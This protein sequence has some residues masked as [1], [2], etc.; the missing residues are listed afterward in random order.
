MDKGLKEKI[1]SLRE[2][3]KSYREISKELNCS[4]SLISY[5]CKRWGLSDIGLGFEKLDENKKQDIKEYYKNHT[6]KETAEKFKVSYSSVEYYS[7]KKR[8]LLTNEEKKERNYH[9]V[10][11]RRQKLKRIAIEYKGGKCE[12]CGYDKDFPWVYDFHHV[13][14][15]NK[16]F[17]ISSYSGGLVGMLI[18]LDKCV[19]LC[20]NCH[21]E[22]H[23]QE[24][25]G[26]F[27]P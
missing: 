16:D 5:H 15:E 26:E 20:A 2:N 13:N 12:K 27:I 11:T 23:Y 4:R 22:L 18:E 21:R 14:G 6:K 10:K 7:D 1:L 17:L 24:F 19:M 25:L 9:R 3:G 8:I